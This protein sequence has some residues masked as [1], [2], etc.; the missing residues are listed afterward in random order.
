[1][2]IQLIDGLHRKEFKI[3]FFV[4]FLLSIIAFCIECSEFYGSSMNFVRG[5]DEVNIMNGISGV[6]LVLTLVMPL[7]SGLI[8][9]S[10]YVDEKASGLFRYIVTRKKIEKYLWEKAAVVFLLNF[11]T[12]LLPILLN[13]F[14]CKLFFPAVNYSNMYGMPAFS[15]WLN[16]YPR[17]Y[18]DILRVKYEFWYTLLLTFNTCLFSGLIGMVIFGILFLVK[19]NKYKVIAGFY[20]IFLFLEILCETQ[21][22]WSIEIFSYCMPMSYG[23]WWMQGILIMIWLGSGLFLIQLGIQKE[24]SRMELSDE[25]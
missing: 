8:Y 9:A 11:F 4:V 3:S 10:S 22:L 21:D 12:F 18:A 7:V 6:N 17:Q 15:G 25:H 16:Y 24:K 5:A 20:V 19:K 14:L 23:N 1:M 13:I 2:Y